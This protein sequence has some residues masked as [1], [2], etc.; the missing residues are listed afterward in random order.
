M[1]FLTTVKHIFC[2]RRSSEKSK[3]TASSLISC[4]THIKTKAP[5]TATSTNSRQGNKFKYEDGRRFHADQDVSYILP[6][7]DDETDRVHQQHWI[8]R[9]ALQC[10]YHAPVTKM[11][12]EGIVV[13]D[14]GCGP[15]TWT[16]EMGEN[17]PQSKFYG[18]DASR[19]FPEDIKPANVDFVIGNIA[20]HIPFPDNTFDYIHQRLLFLGLTNNDWENALKELFRVL[21]PGGYIELVEPDLQDLHNVGPV[22]KKLQDTLSEILVSRDMPTKVACQ[23]EE[24]LDKAGFMNFSQK[25]TPLKLNHTNKAGELLWED[26]YHG[27]CNI[28]SVLALGDSDWKDIK[29]YEEF[30][31]EC[32]D[33]A[34]K[35]KTC[36]NYYACYAQKPL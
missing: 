28:R 11:L 21:K 32:G 30:L 4:S 15:A 33:E 24:R 7:D 29:V 34:K 16:F 2:K 36:I 20:K 8:L 6:N 23:L 18:I 31:K 5:S 3:K 10:N 12:E 14:S 9:Y 26:Y 35:Y 25:M 27:F 17:Y 13:L 1:S 19:V 22:L